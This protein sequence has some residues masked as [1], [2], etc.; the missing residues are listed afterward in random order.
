M[1]LSDKHEPT[2]TPDTI[3]KILSPA[4]KPSTEPTNDNKKSSSKKKKNK[5]TTPNKISIESSTRTNRKRVKAQVVSDNDVAD[6]N[7]TIEIDIMLV[8]YHIHN[9]FYSIQL[10]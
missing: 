5:K 8:S 2:K 10:Y 3:D 1:I 9:Y 6:V 4:S 7:V